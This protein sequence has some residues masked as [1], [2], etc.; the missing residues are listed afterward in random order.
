[1][2]IPAIHSICLAACAALLA[3]CGERPSYFAGDTLLAKAGH[4]E[5]YLQEVVRLTPEG[6]AGDD[7]VEF[8]ELYVDRWIKKQ[9]KLQEA[10]E[11]FSSSADDIDALVEEYRQSLLIRKLDQYYV[12]RQVDTTFTENEIQRYYNSHLGDFTLDRVLVK[13]RIMRFGE[14]YRQPR[15]LM[16]LMR[17]V[18]PASRKD[19]EDL[20]T[21]N[22][23]SLTEYD[24]WVDFRTFL[25]NLPAVGARDYTPLLSSSD[26]QQMRDDNS[27]YYF[28]ITAVRRAGDPQPLEI[29]RPTIRRILFNRR[30]SELIR[31]REEEMLEKARAERKVRICTDKEKKN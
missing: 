15:K 19:L 9:L 25:S 14:G 8:V 12:D 31:E 21:K 16:A 3:G 28:H 22:G 13:G 5:L 6:L 7:S 23:F 30:Q 26:V 24:G 4:R 20:C 10:E 1:M 18:A 2:R 11:L 27:I 17:A 29:A